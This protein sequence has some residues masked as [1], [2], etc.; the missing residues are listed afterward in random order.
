MGGKKK[1]RGGWCVRGLE[2]LQWEG[3]LVE[4]TRE[5]HGR[6]W[7]SRLGVVVCERDGRERRAAVWNKREAVKY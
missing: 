1:L 4:G 6:V 2:R 5:W 7:E 3:V